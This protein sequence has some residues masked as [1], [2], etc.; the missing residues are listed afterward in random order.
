MKLD[1]YADKDGDLHGEFTVSGGF[2][3]Y[4][5]KEYG[6]DADEFARQQDDALRFVRGLLDAFE[7]KR[8]GQE[9]VIG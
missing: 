6:D 9:G 3:I 8:P 7:K 1:L 2:G 5:E 4:G